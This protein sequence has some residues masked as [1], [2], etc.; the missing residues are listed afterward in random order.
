MYQTDSHD[1][2]RLGFHS[3]S[4]VLLPQILCAF[5]DPEFDILLGDY[6]VLDRI[7]TDLLHNIDEGVAKVRAALCCVSCTRNK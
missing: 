7:P 5:E 4:A 1:C 6:S 3:G 2:T